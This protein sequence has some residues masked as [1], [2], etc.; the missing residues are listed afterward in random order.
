MINFYYKQL[1]P[2]GGT[3][4][5]DPR[6]LSLYM[7]F[8]IIFPANEVVEKIYSEILKTHGNKYY[9]LIIIILNNLK[10]FDSC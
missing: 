8:N 2:G 3:N 1:P 5:V 6:Y 7:S 4:Y 10:Y 9:N